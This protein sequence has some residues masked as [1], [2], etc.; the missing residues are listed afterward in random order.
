MH[1]YLKY[2]EQDLWCYLTR[3]ILDL[4]TTVVELEALNTWKYHRLQLLYRGRHWAFTTTLEYCIIQNPPMS[5]VT[6]MLMDF[7]VELVTKR[8]VEAWERNAMVDR[9]NGSTQPDFITKLARVF[10]EGENGKKKCP[11]PTD[12]A[13][14]RQS[15][16]NFW[17]AAM[18]IE[19]EG[20]E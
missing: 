17:K 20:T 3:R 6:Q 10:Y 16:L 19:I 7:G 12:L 1:K 14:E 4:A 5:E 8:G 9:E 13:F 11:L 18:Q 15:T 2:P